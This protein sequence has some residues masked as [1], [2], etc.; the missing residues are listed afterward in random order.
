MS[1]EKLFFGISGSDGKPLTS[2]QKS[3]LKNLYITTWETIDQEFEGA[4]L[5]VSTN[6][7]RG[8]KA[9][10]DEATSAS[11]AI[12]VCGEPIVKKF[13]KKHFSNSKVERN[14]EQSVTNMWGENRRV[15]KCASL[16]ISRAHHPKAT[17]D[18]HW[19]NRTWQEGFQKP[20]QE[21][22]T[23]KMV[24]HGKYIVWKTI[25]TVVANTGKIIAVT[26]GV[27]PDIMDMLLQTLEAVNYFTKGIKLWLKR[28]RPTKRREESIDALEDLVVNHSVGST[29]AG[30]IL[31]L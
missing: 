19:V 25:A 1:E 10:D 15:A 17:A 18:G 14:S 9:R 24:K 21:S 8:Q 2:D 13:M 29:H 27:P 5:R 16:A 6:T 26:L 12:K 22:N 28:N 4:R 30:D 31:G 23:S 7:H 3:A 20:M 11:M